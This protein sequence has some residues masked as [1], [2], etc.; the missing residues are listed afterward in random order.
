MPKVRRPRHGSLQFWPR[1]RSKKAYAKVKSWIKTNNTILQGFAGYKAGMTHIAIKDIRPHSLTKGEIIVWPVTVIECPSLK[2]VSIRLYKK[3]PYG[4]KVISEVFNP[5]LDKELAKKMSMPK[6]EKDQ[7]EKIEKLR[8]R[9]PE[10]SEIRI[11]VHT[12]PKKTGIGKK[13]PEIFEL[14]IGGNINLA[15]EYAKGLFNKE[16]KASEILKAGTKVDIHSVTKGKGFQ[17]AVK[18]FGIQLRSHKS[19]KKRRGNNFGPIHPSHIHWGVPAPGRMGFHLRTEYNKELLLIGDNPEKINPKGG[20]LHY[21]QIKSEYV[22]IKGSVGGSTKRLITLT[23]PIRGTK[24]IGNTFEIQ[25]ISQES[26]Q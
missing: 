14:G 18:R 17:G 3:T 12:Q 2:L 16:I 9:L 15:F 21:G 1:K 7:E 4:L 6:K 22:L 20:F 24:G 8:L 25:Y 19:E 26:K 11:I 10:I 13:L 5:K 23:E